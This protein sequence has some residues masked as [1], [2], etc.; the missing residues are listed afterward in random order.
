MAPEQLQKLI[1]FN[2]AAM[3]TGS[4]I[5]AAATA[6][7]QR[8]VHSSHL[9]LTISQSEVAAKQWAA[10]IDRALTEVGGEAAPVNH[11]M[12]AHY[13]V[14]RRIRQFASD[15][16]ARDLSI[17]ASG[18]RALHYWIAFFGTLRTYAAQAGLRQT[19]QEMQASLHEA[20]QADEQYTKLATQLL[21]GG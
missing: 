16:Y 5:A 13:E 7:I 21:S 1:T 10:R 17:I 18:Q 2:L 6:E 15:A 20:Q 11:I 3:K 9:Q 8:D 4:D 19:E 14:D 12:T